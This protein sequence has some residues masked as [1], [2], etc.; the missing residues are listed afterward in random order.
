MIAFHFQIGY[1]YMFQNG[2]PNG[3]N[4]PADSSSFTSPSSLFVATNE[5]NYQGVPESAVYQSSYILDSVIN[6]TGFFA[7]PTMQVVKI[8]PDF[9]LKKSIEHKLNLQPVKKS[10]WN[11]NNISLFVCDTKTVSSRVTCV[12]ALLF[13]SNYKLDLYF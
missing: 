1:C 2:V 3:C 4:V 9:I 6:I 12:S 13:N 5:I 11:S 8:F 7:L 10:G